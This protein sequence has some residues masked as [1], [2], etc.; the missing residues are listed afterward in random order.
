MKVS[1]ILAMAGIIVFSFALYIILALYNRFFVPS[2]LKN[3][4]LYNDSL[5]T[6]SDIDEAI[7]GFI[8]KNKIE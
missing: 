2:Y 8:L 5:K 1:L 6:P 7:K 3:H 4:D